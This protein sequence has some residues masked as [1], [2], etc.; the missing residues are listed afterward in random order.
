MLFRLCLIASS[1]LDASIG[2][3]TL[4]QENEGTIAFDGLNF[5][6]R[7]IIGVSHTR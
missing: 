2:F 5:A 4:R 1:G 3:E 7:T 6:A